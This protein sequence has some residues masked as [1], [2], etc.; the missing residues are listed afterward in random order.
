[1]KYFPGASRRLA[2]L[3]KVPLTDADHAELDQLDKELEKFK[4]ANP[5]YIPGA[6]F[7]VSL[8]DL[9]KAKGFK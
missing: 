4:K 2:L 8:G 9:L 3:T 1:M 6:E 5:D 7:K